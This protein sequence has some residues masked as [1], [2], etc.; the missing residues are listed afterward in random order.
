M[1]DMFIWLLALPTLIILLWLLW[2]AVTRRKPTTF[3][4]GIE[5]SIL[6]CKAINWPHARFCRRCG[7]SL[8]FAATQQ[9]VS[10]MV[11]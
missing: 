11:G 2:T 1:A 9:A 8:R 6:K 5:C 3:E 4:H 7:H 10:P